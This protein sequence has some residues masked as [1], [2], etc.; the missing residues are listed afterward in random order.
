MEE[1]QTGG[2]LARIA[3]PEVMLKVG[4]LGEDEILNE[5]ALE[6]RTRLERV[7]GSLL[8]S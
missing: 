4:S 2:S 1:D 3:V 8:A 7:A 5:V 6:A